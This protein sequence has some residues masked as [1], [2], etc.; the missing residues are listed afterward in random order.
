M[1]TMSASES[2]AIGTRQLFTTSPLTSTAQAPHSPSPHPSL[3]PVSF[4]SS[5][6]T[7]SSRVRGCPST[8]SAF[9]FTVQR[10]VAP[11]ILDKRT[12]HGLHQYLRSDRN[13]IEADAGRVFNRVNDGGRRAIDGQFADA[14]RSGWTVSVRR[15]FE[16]NSDARQIGGRGP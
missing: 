10:T 16:V 3:A 5:R 7:S 1:V 6:S 14:L 15:F 4:K 9:P 11:A 12:V 8:V 2:C 13:A